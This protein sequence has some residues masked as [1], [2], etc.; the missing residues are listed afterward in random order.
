MT[1]NLMRITG[2]SVR[3]YFCIAWVP[4]EIQ[5]APSLANLSA[6]SLSDVGKF[7]KDAYTV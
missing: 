7:K 2:L 1:F 6:Q 5:L 3:A 4:L